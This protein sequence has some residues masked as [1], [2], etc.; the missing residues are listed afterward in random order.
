MALSLIQQQNPC[1]LLVVKC[2]SQGQRR[3]VKFLTP[4]EIT[5]AFPQE[6][7]LKFTLDKKLPA[8]E[9]IDTIHKCRRSWELKAVLGQIL[10]SG[11]QQSQTTF[12]WKELPLTST[13][14]RRNF[15]LVWRGF[16]KTTLCL[17]YYSGDY[18]QQ[19]AQVPTK[20]QHHHQ[21]QLQQNKKM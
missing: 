16:L 14:G 9:G 13:S 3:Q 6:F 11:Q 5:E 19:V 10:L 17:R 7:C 15:F 1:G 20:Q 4:R 8:S 2:P 18:E 21:Q 12:S